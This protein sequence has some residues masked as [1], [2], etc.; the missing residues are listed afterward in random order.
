MVNFKKEYAYHGVANGLLLGLLLG[1]VIGFI[2]KTTMTFY[3]AMIQG[4]IFGVV[5]TIIYFI[6]SREFFEG[7]FIFIIVGLL[8]GSTIAFTTQTIGFFWDRNFSFLEWA[9]SGTTMITTIAA[10]YLIKITEK[11]I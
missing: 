3:S 5:G 4:L 7:L 6:V 10:T 2:G 9:F 11:R 1:L 8:S